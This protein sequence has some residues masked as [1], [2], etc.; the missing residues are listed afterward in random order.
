MSSSCVAKH[1]FASVSELAADRY[2]WLRIHFGSASVLILFPAKQTT[3]LSYV[4]LLHAFLLQK[5]PE[6]LVH[7]WPQ[8][9]SN[10]IK[11]CW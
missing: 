8:M 4:F 11:D 2:F 3:K 7:S 5:F 9:F 1:R 6:V 10:R